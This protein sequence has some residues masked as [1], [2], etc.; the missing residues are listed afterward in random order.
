MAAKPSQASNLTAEQ[1]PPDDL[2]VMGQVIAPFGIK[3]WL[4][5]RGFTEET[6]ALAGYE[7]WWLQLASGWKRFQLAETAVGN[8]GMTALLAEIVDRT[9]AETLRN[10]SI[11]LSRSELPQ[12]DA[13]EFYWADLVGFNVITASQETIGVLEGLLETGS[14]DVLVVKGDREHL[15]PAALI[16]EVD[17]QGKTICAD[18]GLDY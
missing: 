11:A 2:V 1:A 15:I 16:I 5:I 9:Q 7:Y 4:R 18:W 12:L 14:A 10:A 13:D 3:G 6:D 17:P 8:K